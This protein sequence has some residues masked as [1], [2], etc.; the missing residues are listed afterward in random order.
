LDQAAYAVLFVNSELLDSEFVKLVE[1]PA[2]LEAAQRDGLLLLALRVSPCHRPD[3]LARIQFS[4]EEDTPLGG[5]RK[6]TR[7][8]AYMAVA[9]RVAGYLTGSDGPSQAVRLMEGISPPPAAGPS[10]GLV[11]GL[12]SDSVATTPL[13][14]A[15]VLS[16]RI[17]ED[18]E[19]IREKYQR[20]ERDAAVVELDKLLAEP[21]WLHLDASLQGRI[22]RTA[23]LYRLT[24]GD[25]SEAEALATRAAAEDPE[26]DAQVLKTQ[27]ALHRGAR[28]HASR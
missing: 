9:E 27:L 6:T 14:L 15:D 11:V 10:S 19:A 18:L 3:W 5:A 20:G 17:A 2:L 21:A 24:A 23:T 8:R 7:D 22:L 26:G 25:A 13:D 4:N 1:L 12:V 28:G 16:R